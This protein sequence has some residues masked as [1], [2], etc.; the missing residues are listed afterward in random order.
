MTTAGYKPQTLATVK[1]LDDEY[2]P[3]VFKVSVMPWLVMN[4]IVWW[5]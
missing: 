1:S 4:R 3:G 5:W 2:T